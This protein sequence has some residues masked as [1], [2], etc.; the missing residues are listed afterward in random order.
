M[1]DFSVN[2]AFDPAR[3][4]LSLVEGTKIIASDR[5]VETVG[6]GGTRDPAVARSEFPVIPGASPKETEEPSAV[7]FLHETSDRTSKVASMPDLKNCN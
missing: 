4:Q 2:N 6:E 5:Y 1:G 7:S 3:T